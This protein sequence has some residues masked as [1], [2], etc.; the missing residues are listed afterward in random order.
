MVGKRSASTLV[1]SAVILA[2]FLTAP[3]AYASTG[4]VFLTQFGSSGTGD[5]QFNQAWGVAVSSGHVFVS[6]LN[7]RINEFTTTGTFLGWLGKC[8]GGSNCDTITDTSIGFTCTASTCTGLTFGSGDGQ[9]NGPRGVAVD[10]A[11]NLYVVD[12]GNQRIQV[13]TGT[14]TFV[15][16]WGSSGSGDGQFAFPFGI[17]VQGSNVYVADTNNERAQ[18]FT[19]TGSFITTW[20]TAA[21]SGCSFDEPIGIAAA[22]AGDVYVAQ[23]ANNC[24][25]EFTSSGTFIGWAGGCISGSSCDTITDASIGFTCTAT[26]CTMPIHGSNDG[27]FDGPVGV[28]TD[29]KN[30]VFVVDSGNLR[31]QEFSKTGAFS[32]AF[33]SGGCAGGEFGG[34]IVMTTDSLGVVYVTDSNG[35]GCSINSDRVEE[36]SLPTTATSVTCSPSKVASGSPTTCTVTVT[37]TGST[38]GTPTGQV[39]FKSSAAG[40]FSATKCT[41]SGT[42]TSASCSVTFTPTSTGHHKI[43]ATYQGDTSHAESQGTFT[44]KVT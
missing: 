24:V 39:K 23:T 18:E 12:E 17:A 9:F 35:T 7:E 33:G 2:I 30:D 1:S 20:N 41:L 43:T 6:D 25:D 26:T 36:F 22:P 38:T 13:F 29:S 42:G 8:T 21:G 28:A 40:T 31:I 3:V 15:R 14:G 37:D 34:P 10:A 44:L 11:G 5:G 16:A 19:T 32:N 4:Y 27:Q